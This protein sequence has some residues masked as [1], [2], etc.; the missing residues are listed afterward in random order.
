MKIAIEIDTAEN[1][2][3]SLGIAKEQIILAYLRECLNESG[4]ADILGAYRLLVREDY[5]GENK[6]EIEISLDELREK[7]RCDPADAPSAKERAQE[8]SGGTPPTTDNQ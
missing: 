1:P 7:L 2:A 8:E 3:I 5:E 4:F 6:E